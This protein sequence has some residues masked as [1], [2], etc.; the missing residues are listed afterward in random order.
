MYSQIYSK[1]TVGTGVVTF[2]NHDAIAKMKQIEHEQADVR[3]PRHIENKAA[4]TDEL[5]L[6][7][8]ML[9]FCDGSVECD[10]FSLIAAA[11]LCA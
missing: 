2:P 5:L 7:T 11:V 6:L 9:A 3:Q 8:A 1:R 10:L 4:D